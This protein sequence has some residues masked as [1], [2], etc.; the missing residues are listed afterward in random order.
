ETTGGEDTSEPIFDITTDAHT[1]DSN[2]EGEKKPS[3]LLP[4]IIGT[5]AAIAAVGTGMFILMKRKKK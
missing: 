2:R 3:S 1:E 5:A 4:I